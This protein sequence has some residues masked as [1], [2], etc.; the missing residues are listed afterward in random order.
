MSDVITKSAPVRELSYPDLDAFIADVEAVRASHEART[1]T[2]TGNWTAGQCL[3]HLA[4]FMKGSMDGFPTQKPPLLLRVL[5]RL[6][7]K[8]IAL[9]GAPAKPGIRLPTSVAWLDPVA[10]GVSSFE[11]GYEPIKSIID[12]Y[13]AGERF[14]HDSP[15]FGPLT[16]EEWCT[17]HCGHNAMHMSF[18]HPGGRAGA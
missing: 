1:L 15:I 5:G 13:R 8:R 14:T 2:H 18:Q 12:R 17:L 3:W 6:V 10:M 11:E 7:F 4:V 16:H 9:S